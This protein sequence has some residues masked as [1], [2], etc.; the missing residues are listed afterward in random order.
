MTRRIRHLLPLAALF[1]T[2]L[3]AKPADGHE[4]EAILGT[5][6]VVPLHLRIDTKDFAKMQPAAPKSCC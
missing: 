3:P 1:V 5:T 6:K 2:I 4:G